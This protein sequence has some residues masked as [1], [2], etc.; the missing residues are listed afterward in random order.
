MKQTAVRKLELDK[1]VDILSK[2]KG[3]DFYF[4]SYAKD[5]IDS[6]INQQNEKILDFL[7]SEITERRDYSASKMCE[8]IAEFIENNL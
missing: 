2:I 3:D 1:I 4:R 5:I 6:Y 8:V 7:H